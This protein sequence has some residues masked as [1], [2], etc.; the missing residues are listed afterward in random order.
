MPERET[1]RVLVEPA[2]GGKVAH[3]ERN[4]CNTR[5]GSSR[6]HGLPGLTRYCPLLAV[7]SA[8]ISSSVLNCSLAIRLV[9]KY[10]TQMSPRY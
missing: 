9:V 5:Y 6:R 10:G 1:E 2:H 8:S 4:L 7:L 3:A